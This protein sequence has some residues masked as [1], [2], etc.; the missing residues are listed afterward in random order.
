MLIFA[1]H[2]SRQKSLRERLGAV[3]RHARAAHIAEATAA[4]YGFAT[5]AAFLTFLGKTT[6]YAI[7]EFHAE[8]FL[9]RLAELGTPL[10]DSDRAAVIAVA[11]TVNESVRVPI[12]D[13]MLRIDTFLTGEPRFQ[14]MVAYNYLAQLEHIAQTGIS[15]R[16]S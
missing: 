4:G 10:A 3:L 11:A 15:P 7:G 2:E 8:R 16:R 5:H 1:Y 6:A 13:P 14:P 12:T 9:Q